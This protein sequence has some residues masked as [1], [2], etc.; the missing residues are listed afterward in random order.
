MFDVLNEAV[1]EH[2][3]AST[4]NLPFGKSQIHELTH[5]VLHNPEKFYSATLYTQKGIHGHF[6]IGTPI[7]NHGLVEGVIIGY[8]A[9]DLTVAF[10]E[11]RIA[12]SATIIPFSENSI[13]TTENPSPEPGIVRI[14]DFDLAVRLVPDRELISQAG[15]L[16]IVR[17]VSAITLVLTM[18]F[19]I[20]LWLGRSF[21]L[22][23]HAQLEEQAKKLSQLAAVAKNANEAILICDLEG[24]VE[25]SNPAFERISGC[26]LAQALALPPGLF[27]WG[28]KAKD[29]DYSKIR[30]AV[31]RLE[32]TEGEIFC[33]S[34]DGI[35]FWADV[36]V[37]PLR[38][39][40]GIVYGLIGIFSD[41]TEARKQRTA[42]A[43]AQEKIQHQ[44]MHDS[45]TGLPNR[46]ALDLALQER[47]GDENT[48]TAIVRIDLDHF[49]YINDSAGH[50]AGD[51]VLVE[52][53]RILLS[54]T[55]AKDLAARTGGDEFVILLGAGT[56]S[57]EAL[58]I[59]E[60]L[61]EAIKKPIEHD[62]KQLFVGASFGIAGTK[63]GLLAVSE[64]AVGAD[65]ALYIAKNQ[66]RNTVQFYTPEIHNGVLK[67]RNLASEI[68]LA[69]RRKE[70]EPYFQPQFDAHTYEVTGV[71]VLMRWPSSKLGMLM[72][73]EVLP[74]A[75][76]MS[77]VGDIDR[78]VFQ[79]GLQK[80]KELKS[81]GVDIPKISFN[82]TAERLMDP[83]LLESL[84]HQSN[85]S[86]NISFEILESVLLEGENSTLA[87]QL[88]RLRSA[89]ARVE[90]DDFG[91]GHASIAS[92]VQTMPDYM[93]IDKQLVIPSVYS[94]TARKLV[95]SI[96]GIAQALEI[97]VI[98]EGV[99]TL[100][101]ANFLA[102]I[103]CATLQ[104]FFFAKPMAKDELREFLLR[105]Q[106]RIHSIGSEARA[107]SVIGNL[108]VT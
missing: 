14:E 44:A 37:A 77:L 64:L 86:I 75:K 85:S 6:L 103:G 8:L 55:R 27:L 76:K 39:D 47:T 102:S 80:I 34:A 79:K 16:L 5:E 69:T 94:E 61:L 30:S 54:E 38:D 22:S 3:F 84:L 88:D 28:V 57:K 50:A 52:V 63:D 95:R 42:F 99:E 31:K 21:V 7:L 91:T 32:P 49:K 26:S 35:V 92:L 60:R 15:R 13:A 90:I 41:V 105:H 24:M 53:A 45:L 48:E 9:I 70:F 93:K 83:R 11:N 19:S 36:S 62:G 108:R 58:T 17:S 89:G 25:W 66:G 98:A 106:L 20:F 33:E 67:E 51:Q 56:S 1:A 65:A 2:S 96:V 73:D 68:Q 71:E 18:A 4:S 40:K 104:G 72:P 12:R 87:S 29:S 82:V 43:K 100:E 23:P 74:I 59:A 97:G 107:Q 10:S 101:H 78:I 46:R 81:E